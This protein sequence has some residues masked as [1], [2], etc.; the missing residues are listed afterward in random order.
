MS[1]KRFVA[2]VFAACIATAGLVVPA[3]AA[4]EAL[5]PDHGERDYVPG[6]L[7]VRY[8]GSAERSEVR[9]EH[10][11]DKIES[12]A[13]PNT[14]LVQ[15]EQGRVAEAAAEV[16]A[17]PD[18][19]Y[20]EPNYLYRAASVPND[21]LFPQLWGL[22]QASDV[23]MDAPQAWD[24][25]TGSPGVA[26]AVV[27]TGVA[28]DHPELAPAIWRNPGET[29]GGQESNGVDDDGNGYVDDFQ[30]WDWVGDD[31]H[32]RDL[33]GH[34]THVAATIGAAGNDG[35]GI[36][37]VA[38]S[39]RIMALRALNSNGV[40]N[41]ADLSSAFAYAARAG[42]KVVNVSLGG[43]AYS[44]AV[45]NAI[46]SAPNTLFVVA[47]G[48]AGANNDIGASYPCNYPV[49]NIVCV[50]AMD[51]GDRL[52]PFSN[53]G[54]TTVDLAA[55]GVGILS[56]QPSFD[57]RFA[58]DFTGG[59]GSRWAVGGVNGTWA[60]EPDGT[61]ADSPGGFYQDNADHWIATTTPF[62]LGGMND[63]LLR[64][65]MKLD[66]EQGADVLA[67]EAS[68]DG[69][70]WG[71]IG[72]WTGST[73]GAWERVTE[74]IFQHDGT[75]SLY[76]RFRLVSNG[77]VTADG[78]SIDTVSVRCNSTQ[79]PASQGF[80]AD[81]TS[82][83][84]PHVSGAAALA[85]SAQPGATVGAVAQALLEGAEDQPA[86][87]GK[88]VSGGRLNACSTVALM[89]SVPAG[90]CVDGSGA[91]TPSPTPVATPT[92]TPPVTPTPTTATPTPAAS[93]SATPT[94]SPTPSPTPTPTPT[95]TP[96]AT[97]TATPAASPTPV[98][99][100]T[101]EPT[102]TPP[103]DDAKDPVY[104]HE[105]IVKLRLVNGVAG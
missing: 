75:V 68:R 12:L 24:V 6:E 44:L 93:P 54:A 9:R 104:V 103:P 1:S 61:I 55:P 11:L 15:V 71:R 37:G 60:A 29:G 38:W 94:P 96:A 102:P 59:F 88:T 31:R 25:T 92:P 16:T 83:A 67:I 33:H 74:S 5:G 78:A 50:A 13:L 91:A 66:L 36:A 80:Y 72:G 45:L 26:V 62:D 81:G 21:P 99:T 64:Y 7:V 105:R 97:P 101:L 28:I 41:T 73:G 57:V 100:P 32:P 35:T 77:S 34:G 98:A 40:G 84:T 63:C 69:S 2:A 70:S 18:V 10:G 30:G 87:F 95:P 90:T 46:S 85:W 4:P 79:Y 49:P 56:L 47:A 52:A 27:D 20:A 8:A 89:A 22:H 43:D 53:Y 76:V 86:Y 3:G 65:S 48:N 58:E 39:S 23:D 14:E 19:V 51:S 42:A 17:D 82:M